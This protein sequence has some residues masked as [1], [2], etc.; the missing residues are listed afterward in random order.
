[1][2]L[3][4]PVP[5]PVPTVRRSVERPA[6]ADDVQALAERR[7]AARALLRTPMLR[8]EDPEQTETLRLVRRHRD[9]LVRLFADGLGYR[10]VVEHDVA[11][12]VKA[13]LG[14]DASRPL[15][16]RS[17]RPFTPRTYALLC[18]AVAALT[19]TRGQLLVDE[20]VA[21]VRAAAADAGLDVDLDAVADRRALHAALLA[22]V[23]LGVLTERDGDLEHWADQR[24]AALLD[25]R[26]ERLGLLVAAQVAGAEDPDGLLEQ[27]ALPSSVGGARIAVRRRLVESPVLT[28]ADLPAEQAEWWARNRRRETEWF[29]AHV[30]L[31]LELRAEGALAVDPDEELTDLAFP[32]TGSARQLALLWLDAVVQEVRDE[33]R[34]LPAPERSRFRVPRARVRA[35][36][37]QVLHR[38]GA[39]LKRAYRAD[40]EAALAEAQDLLVFTGLVQTTPSDASSESDGDGVDWLVHAAAARYATAP[41]LS[42]AAPSGEASL[43]DLPDDAGGGTR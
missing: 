30:G 10:L 13:G 8:S 14:R 40:P 31:E 9:E 18:L 23:D 5:P 39:G 7:A 4:T 11:R 34:E 24:T 1:M 35:A 3:P 26:R 37:H 20:L 22:L 43:F 12:L 32:G 17:G 27:A 38:W 6:P 42:A 15:L 21:E 16:R 28:V 33:A 25:V 36:G 41:V 2:T 19:R 29:R